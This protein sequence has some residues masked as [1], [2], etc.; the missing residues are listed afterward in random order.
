[1]KI[2]LLFSTICA[3]RASVDENA[4]TAPPVRLRKKVAIDEERNSVFLMPT[5]NPFE[6]IPYITSEEE[7]RMLPHYGD[8]AVIA[9]PG[10][11]F[12]VLG[13]IGYSGVALLVDAYLVLFLYNYFFGN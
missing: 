5:L 7:E 8:E 9:G 3:V 1:M 4:R 11:G 2:F 13:L 10:E 6:D 12:M